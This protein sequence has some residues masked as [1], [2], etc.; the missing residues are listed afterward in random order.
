MISDNTIRNHP[1][2]AYR[3]FCWMMYRELPLNDNEWLLVRKL[4]AAMGTA[5]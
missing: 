1:T 4:R 5:K 2:T 3:L